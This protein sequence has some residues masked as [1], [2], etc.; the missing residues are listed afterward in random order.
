MIQT[1]T[2][3]DGQVRSLGYEDAE[4]KAT[5]GVMLPCEYTF[6][7]AA[8]ETMTVVTGCLTAMLPG[9]EAFV[10]YPAGQSFEVP[11]DSAFDL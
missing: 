3:F 7:T 6:N 5:V 8:P 10:D 9:S 11:G 4:G 1:N 2:Y